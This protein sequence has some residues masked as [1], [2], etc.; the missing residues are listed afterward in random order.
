MSDTVHPLMGAQQTPENN[1]ELN[2][3]SLD[4]QPHV[5]V[6]EHDPALRKI[7]EISLVQAGVA[8]AT[9]DRYAN[10]LQILQEAPPDIFI[11]ISICVTGTR[12]N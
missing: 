7:M 4:R 1:M 10:A 6:L 3:N 9:V 5:L 11:V 8:V 12:E 2:K